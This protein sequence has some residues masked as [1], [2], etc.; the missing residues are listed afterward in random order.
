MFHA[1]FVKFSLNGSWSV[2]KFEYE[3]LAF[4][5]VRRFNLFIVNRLTMIY[6]KASDVNKL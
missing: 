5:A 1:K 3:R 2:V 6:L 4:A